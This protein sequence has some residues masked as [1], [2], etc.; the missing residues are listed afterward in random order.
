MTDAGYVYDSAFQNMASVGSA[1]AARRVAQALSEMAP[2]RSVIDLGCAQGE[3]L[4]QWRARGVTDILGVDGDYV[5]RA[6]LRIPAD[7]FV[8]HDLAT[9][10]AGTRR[11]D[12]AQSLE[13]AEHLPA[14]RAAAFVADLTGLAD[15]V[16]FSAAPP[17]QGGEHHINEREAAYWQ[18]LF[19]AH[20]YVAVDALRPLLAGD[21]AAPAWYRYNLLL[22]VRREALGRLS[23]AA[24][25]RQLAEGE[26]VRDVSPPLYR[27]RKLLIRALPPALRDLLARLNAR[28][29]PKA[30]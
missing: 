2:I 6:R 9:P 19:A 20:G 29:F 16:L 22:Y 15:M 10:Y 18:D 21:R 5:D 17:G 3:W 12:L 11:F 1:Y 23:P 26:A 25:R 14:A 28:R 13:V 30:A 4:A 27:I 24:R 7:A 8:T